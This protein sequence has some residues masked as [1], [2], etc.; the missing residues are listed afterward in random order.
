VSRAS[1]KSFARGAGTGTG[2]LPRW[3]ICCSP[4]YQDFQQLLFES[5]QSPNLLPARNFLTASAAELWPV[6]KRADCRL[7]SDCWSLT[8]EPY[9]RSRKRHGYS[10]HIISSLEI[11]NQTCF[12][13]WTYQERKTWSRP[14]MN[15]FWNRR[16]SLWGLRSTGCTWQFQLL[17]CW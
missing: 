12:R 11:Q 8:A 1:Q 14:D 3:E 7:T 2:P 13:T 17:S 15:T 16:Q 9:G 4:S 5:L 10:S 6:A